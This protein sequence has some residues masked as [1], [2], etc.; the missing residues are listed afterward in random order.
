MLTGALVGGPDQNDYWEDDRGDYI[1]NE[2]ACDYNAG[3]QTALAGT[4][5]CRQGF[6]RFNLVY[7]KTTVLSVLADIYRYKT[8]GNI[9]IK[10]ETFMNHFTFYLSIRLFHVI[11]FNV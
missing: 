7:N 10:T 4:H 5:K 11:A 6:W 8:L 2:V 9:D 1:M 3:F